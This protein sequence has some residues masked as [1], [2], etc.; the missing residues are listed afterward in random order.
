MAN[1]GAAVPDKDDDDVTGATA[2]QGVKHKRGDAQ[3]TVC[4]W[5]TVGVLMSCLASVCVW[6]GTGCKDGHAPVLADWYLRTDHTSTNP[7]LLGVDVPQ[8][9]VCC[10][11]PADPALGLYP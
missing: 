8:W 3:K 10:T 6:A 7:G 9:N 4:L 2:G 11:S 5:C 1:I